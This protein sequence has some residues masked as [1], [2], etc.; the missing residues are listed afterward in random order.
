MERWKINLYTLWVT[1]VFSLMSFGLGLPFI[2][3]Y[4][5][6][7]GITDQKELNLLVGLATTIPAATMAVAAPIWGIVSDRYGRKMMIMRA[8]VCASILLA[9]M[10]L[11]NNVPLFLGLRALQGIFSGTITASMAFVSANTPEN[12]MSYAL[13]F[14]TSSNF[15]GYAIG[16]FVGGLLAEAMGY[17]F[18]FVTGGVIMAAGFVLVLTLV[19]E[20]KNSYGFRP[21]VDSEDKAK[22]KVLTPFILAVLITV[23]IARIART[24]FT[25]FVPLYVQQTLG[26]VRGAATYTGMINGATGLATAIAS[27]T[28]TRL[29]DRHNKFRLTFLL[30][31]I[32]LPVSLLLL[33]AKSLIA[34]IGVYTV[35]FFVAGGIEP[36]LTSAASETIG[37]QERGRLFG[38]LGTITS[39]A[40]MISPMLGSFIS[41]RF[42]LGA[43]LITIP[44]FMTIQILNL[45]RFRKTNTTGRP[46]QNESSQT[47]T[48][49]EQKEEVTELKEEMVGLKN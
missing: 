27:L 44:V 14:M 29:G 24:V 42:G 41:I 18:C 37:P 8:M 38:M 15:I 49:A 9:A 3:F 2:P 32:A 35:F 20:D 40:T 17:Q 7:M 21:R 28:I 13:G 48:S 36:I 22:K 1:Q 5:Q 23:L 4:F 19:K 31:L 45:I 10:G 12:R 39:V 25:P 43:I 16:P 11:V 34:F 30:C 33:P 47:A 46:P 6:Q 26:T